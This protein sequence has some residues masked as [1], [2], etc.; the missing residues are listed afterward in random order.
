MT[1][2][3]AHSDSP[4]G[5]AALHAAAK[6][7]LL[8]GESLSVLRIIPGVDEPTEDD[9]K[10]REQVAEELSEYSELSWELRRGPEGYDTS[11]SLLD[12][13]E[14]AGATLLVLGSRKRRPVGKLILGSVVQRVLLEST[15]PVLVVKAR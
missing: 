6:E 15:I 1:V 4:R 8:R 7:A 11:E 2:A 9:P 13:A 14:E 12:L 5:K 3:V 10:L